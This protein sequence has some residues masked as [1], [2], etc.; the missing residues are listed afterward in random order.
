MVKFRNYGLSVMDEYNDCPQI[1][2]SINTDD[3]GIFATSLEKEYTLM[4]LAL[5]KQKTA[6]GQPKFQPNNVLNWLEGIR[7][8]AEIQRFGK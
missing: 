5:E 7:Q 8:E 4:A 2:V 6:D 3:K 1:S